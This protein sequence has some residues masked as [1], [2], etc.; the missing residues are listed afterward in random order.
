MFTIF[1]ISNIRFVPFQL[2]L[3]VLV[4]FCSCSSNRKSE[5]EVGNEKFT[6][7]KR[8]SK[9]ITSAELNNARRNLS[10]GP[11]IKIKKKSPADTVRTF[12]KR[13]RKKRFRDAISLTNLAAAVQGLTDNDIKEFNTDLSFLARRVPPQ[14]PINGEIIVANNATVTLKMPNKETNKLELQEI[15]LRKEN[16]NWIILV[17][18]KDGEQA[19]KKEGKNYFFALRID[20]HHKEA[21]AMLDRIGKAQMVYS[22]KNGGKFTDLNTLI[23]NGFVPMDAKTSAS[24]GYNYEV[25]IPTERTTFTALATPAAYGKT[26]KL[27][28]ALRITRDKHPEL[29]SEDLKGKKLLN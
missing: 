27:S 18:D 3:L 16:N 24:T 9:D 1:F 13:L 17:T 5:V 6:L 19:A 15:K 29:I 23:N 11:T 2:I 20:V 28:F 10:S 4:L 26:G 8:R 25:Q 21:K 12:Y 22:I 14:M 7:E